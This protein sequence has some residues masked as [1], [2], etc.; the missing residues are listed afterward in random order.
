LI[1]RENIN[2]NGNNKVMEP[3]AL[4]QIIEWSGGKIKTGTE[5]NGIVVTG[6]STDSRTVKSGELF[7]PLT[8]ENFDGHDYI[9]GAIEKG[10]VAFLSSRDI[11]AEFDG[12]PAVKVEDTLKAYHKIAHNY[13]K[14]FQIP[15][16]AITGS[17]GKTT[18]KDILYHILSKKFKVLATEKNY[19]NEFGLPLTIMKLDST[20]QVAVLE[21]AMRGLGQIRQ[22]CEIACHDIGIITNIGE[23]H[24]E[25]LG[26]YEAIAR[27]KCE[28]LE[29]MKPE[30]TAVL[31]ADDKWFDFCVE[32]APGKVI[33]YGLGL[34]NSADFQ[35]TDKQDKGLDGFLL[36][37]R[38]GENT[39][40]FELPILGV[41]NIYN[42][43]AAIVAADTMGMTPE[44]IGDALK[45]L[46]PSDKR[47][48]MHK[49]PDGWVILNDTYNASPSSMG[50]ALEILSKLK[51][52]GRKLA[53]L[54][55]MLEL[56]EI[57]IQSHRNIGEQI[58][59]AE[60]DELH[61]M[62]ELGREIALGAVDAGMN[63]D[64]VRYWP[65]KDSL[66]EYLIRRLK[67]DDIV[68]VKGSRRMKMEEIVEALLGITTMI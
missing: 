59:D 15:I 24:F 43:L 65:D 55:D 64:N 31:N 34:K 18:T 60:I 5:L 38:Y 62:G 66:M 7:I 32:R 57:A 36:E 8:G 50:K 52:Q 26:S 30:G 28:I 44:E 63:S 48:E 27:A 33:S 42:T 61:V 10:A 37:V 46:R 11:G 40:S 49:S 13:R 53:I 1:I 51:H 6:I 20:Y 45:T 67:K 19:N 21:M 35:V 9:I 3:I 12:F 23:A 17:N 58:A 25:L 47:M 2:G 16:I 22:L 39:H 56:G 54:G 68:L 41:H 14:K 29:N 4:S